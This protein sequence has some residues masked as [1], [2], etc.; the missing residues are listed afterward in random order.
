MVLDVAK[1]RL[2][3]FLFVN[4]SANL[5]LSAEDKLNGNFS[6][7][8][9]NLGETG[10]WTDWLSAVT[11]GYMQPYKRRLPITVQ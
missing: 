10:K 7:Q 3:K 2:S 4:Q 8:Q 9:Q 1:Q 5:P 11:Y 6:M